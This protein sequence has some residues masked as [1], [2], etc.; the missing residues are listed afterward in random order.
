MQKG[1][2]QVSVGTFQ[3]WLFIDCICSVKANSKFFCSCCFSHCLWSTDSLV[4]LVLFDLKAAYLCLTQ[5]RHFF[6]K[7]FSF[8]H[9]WVTVQDKNVKNFFFFTFFFS[10]L[11]QDCCLISSMLFVKTVHQ[12][13]LPPRRP[14]FS[15]III[16]HCNILI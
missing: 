8:S 3:S 1:Q 2:T 15:Q 12:L 5:W 10:Q 14:H 7:T 9:L 16:N 4:K 13:L 6:T 11:L